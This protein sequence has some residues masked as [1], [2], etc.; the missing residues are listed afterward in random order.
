[1][2]QSHTRA[3]GV[4]VMKRLP[5]TVFFGHPKDTMDTFFGAGSLASAVVCDAV[6]RPAR[7]LFVP[8]RRSYDKKGLR[9]PSL[10]DSIDAMEVK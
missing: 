7:Q 2:V 3:G 6:V 10:A 5:S 1:M 8:C 9:Q 4:V